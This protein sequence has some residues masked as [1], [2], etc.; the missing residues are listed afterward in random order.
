MKLHLDICKDIGIPVNFQV[1]VF[2]GKNPVGCCTRHGGAHP[3][4][5]IADLRVI[6]AHGNDLPQ[7]SSRSG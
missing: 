2:D 3:T 5:A 6:Q 7:G 1:V 4:A